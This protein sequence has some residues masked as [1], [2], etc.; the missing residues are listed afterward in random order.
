MDNNK[1]NWL[2]SKENTHHLINILTFNLA[3][4]VSCPGHCKTTICPHLNLTKFNQNPFGNLL[5]LHPLF[6]F[7][8]NWLVF[9]SLKP[10]LDIHVNLAQIS[11]HLINIVNGHSLSHCISLPICDGRRILC[12]WCIIECP[13][14]APT[15]LSSR[16]L[17][18]YYLPTFEFNQ[19]QSKS[20]W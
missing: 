6:Y 1:N 18:N 2:L 12:V 14:S 15:V 20:L 8:W 19:I 16:S 10:W 4:M 13:F 11:S 5:M 9:V 7:S 3:S 17:Q